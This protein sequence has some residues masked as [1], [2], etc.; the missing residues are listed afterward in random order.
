MP[1]LIGDERQ[2]AGRGRGSN[3]W[4]GGAGSLM[5]SVG[6]KM[7]T[8]GLSTS[9]WPRFSLAT[10][11][12]V[13]EM[14]SLSLPSSQ[15]GLKWPNDVWVDGRKVCGILIEQVERRPDRL[16]AGIGLNVNNSF[17]DAP[18]EQRKIAISMRDA[19]IGCSFSRTELL[20]TFL[21]RWRELITMLVEGTLPLVDRWSHSCVLTGHAVMIT[22][23]KNEL[24][25]ICSG[26]DEDGSLLLR[27]AFT[28]ERC[29]AG[30]VRLLD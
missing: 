19:A 23:G 16:I 2:S 22:T 20:T 9:L 30:T 11:I 24:T 21:S 18:E 1:F 25:G 4:G 12:A 5:F 27:T 13:A 3:Q 7:P 26:I 10:G 29:Y 15:I 17:A 14:L 8:L 28:T 6:L